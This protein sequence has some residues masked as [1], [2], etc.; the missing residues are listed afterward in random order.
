MDY[1]QKLNE[2]KDSQKKNAINLEEIIRLI[3]QSDLN[4]ENADLKKKL[5][6]HQKAYDELKI[7]FDSLNDEN[8]KLKL[9]LYEQIM[10][11]KLSIIKLTREKLDLYFRDE[12]QKGSDSL[13]AF[14][15]SFRLKIRTLY[16]I[17]ESELKSD[18]ENFKKKLS[19]IESEIDSAVKSKYEKLAGDEKSLFAEMKKGLENFSRIPADESTIKKRTAANRLEMKI[20]LKWFNILGIIIIIIAVGA[21]AFYIRESLNEYVKGMAIALLGIVFLIG[22]EYFY[23]AKKHEVFGKGLIGGGIGI[24]YSSLFYSYFLLKILSQEAAL[25]LSVLITLSAIILAL[26]NN[27]KTIISLGLIGGYL[28]FIAYII[29]EQGLKNEQFYYAMIYLFII[30][31]LVLSVSLFRKWTVTSY[32]SFILNTPALVYLA[33]NCASKPA[34][35]VYTAITF[36]MYIVITLSYPLKHG[37]PIK[38]PDI[39]LLALS[40]TV[41]AVIIYILIEFMGINYLRGFLAA[42]FC[43]VYLL[44]GFVTGRVLRSEKNTVSLF[45]ITALTFAILMIPFQFGNAGYKSL[46][47]FGWLVEGIFLIIFGYK[48][49]SKIVETAGWVSFILCLVYFYFFDFVDAV[50]S[51]IT[52]YFNFKYLVLSAGMI[53]VMAI[54]QIDFKKEKF[55]IGSFRAKLSGI[56]K[57]FS[58]VNFYIFLLFTTQYYFGKFI[59]YSYDN[60]ITVFYRMLAA[61]AVS[62]ALGYALKRLPV[63]MDRIV[64]MISTGLYIAGDVIFFISLFMVNLN[65]TSPPAG[66]ADIIIFFA[67]FAIM[68]SYN[69]LFLFNAR[70]LL[71]RLFKSGYKLNI[72]L[73]PVFTALAA[74]VTFSLIIGIQLYNYYIH[75]ILSIMYIIMSISFILYGF[76]RK[77][78]Y[79]RY[80]GLVITLIALG[81]LF[82]YDLRLFSNGLSSL[83]SLEGIIATFVYGLLLIGISFIYQRINIKMKGRDEMKKSKKEKR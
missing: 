83:I 1:L 56:I 58:I 73:Y 38:A 8:Q 59:T 10:D 7:K 72:E 23:F 62:L 46:I 4:R 71:V 61:S 50:S 66:L 81:K 27:S 12:K 60:G 55:L 35:I 18:S 32:I 30:N 36:L 16:G 14:N 34:A 47:T 19:I 44:L 52:D 21:F 79:I 9:S 57:Y 17:I 63:I 15:D 31:A 49:G 69:V 80:M 29:S 25:F 43:I 77:Y 76:G 64:N 54:F 78:V 41:S 82:F 68:I 13:S 70:S 28:P 65:L 11:E 37:I 42:V 39:V 48:K 26:V 40:T 67:T 51:G 22:G 24:L 6:Q 74:L 3:E 33:F 20:G 45:H 5:E 75:V 53:S 2:L